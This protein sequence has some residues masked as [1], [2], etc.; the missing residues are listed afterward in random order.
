MPCYI[1]GKDKDLP[2]YS[3]SRYTFESEN[4]TYLE[5]IRE[6]CCDNQR[7]RT[8]CPKNDRREELT[9]IGKD[10]MNK[11]H[12]SMPTSTSTDWGPGFHTSVC[13]PQFLNLCSFQCISNGQ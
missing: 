13:Q 4:E 9:Y 10:L 2:Q 6:N 11:S 5:R 12:V 1:S 3:V 7:Q 8:H